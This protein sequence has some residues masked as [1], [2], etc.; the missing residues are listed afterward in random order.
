MAAGYVHRLDGGGDR[1]QSWA[2]SSWLRLLLKLE[3]KTPIKA[4]RA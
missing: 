1:I 4:L 3:P 2:G